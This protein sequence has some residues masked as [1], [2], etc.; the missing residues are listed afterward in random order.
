MICVDIYYS[1]HRTESSKFLPRK[2]QIL[3]Q[4]PMQER[5]LRKKF[6]SSIHVPRRIAIDGKEKMRAEDRKV[7]KRSLQRNRVKPEL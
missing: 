4:I 5:M 2:L 3:L 6:F 1:H 7:T